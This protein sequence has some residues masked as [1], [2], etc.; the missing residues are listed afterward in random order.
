MKDPID[1]EQNRLDGIVADKFE[2]GMAGQMRD[3]GALAAEVVIETDDLDAV[4]EQP[5]A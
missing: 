4:A 5:L 3:V 2:I 1:L